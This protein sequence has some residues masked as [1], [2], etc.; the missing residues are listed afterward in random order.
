MY[1]VGKLQIN[2]EYRAIAEKIL[3]DQEMEIEALLADS[4]KRL[5]EGRTAK[6][7]FLHSNDKVCIKIYKKPEQITE[8]DFYLPPSQEQAFLNELQ[9]LGI[10]VKDYFNYLF[11]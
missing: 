2:E 8:V 4:S 1:E 9:N 10:K 5:G 3:A 6:I 11:T 7:C